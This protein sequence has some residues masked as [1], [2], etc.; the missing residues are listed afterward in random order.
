MPPV[1]A[2]IIGLNDCPRSR[3]KL[4]LKPSFNKLVDA[5]LPRALFK[6]DFNGN[7]KT[8]STEKVSSHIN[9]RALTECNALVAPEVNAL[10]NF[11]LPGFYN[12]IICVKNCMKVANF[13]II[14]F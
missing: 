9:N 6:N 13:L 4:I 1:I 3:K 8:A 2:D 14:L 11:I 7:E 12:E 10:I 5:V